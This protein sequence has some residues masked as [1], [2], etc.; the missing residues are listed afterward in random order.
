MECENCDK[1]LPVT[2]RYCPYCGEIIPIRKTK[3]YWLRAIQAAMLGSIIAT[4]LVG[5]L[6]G[7]GGWW[8]Q[9][10]TNYEVTNSRPSITPLN[11][12][13]TIPTNNT[14][15]I[16]YLKKLSQITTA[17]DIAI[18]GDYLF[19]T[20]PHG[21]QIFDIAIPAE[22]LWV[23]DYPSDVVPRAKIAI[24][25][26]YLYL[27][28]NT[29]MEIVNMANVVQ[30]KSL[31]TV[32]YNPN[33]AGDVWNV[34]LNRVYAY[35]AAGPHGLHIL[36]VANPYTPHR[37]T[38]YTIPDYEV[39]DVAIV[40]DQAYLALGSAGLWVL[41]IEPLSDIPVRQ[42]ALRTQGVVRRV[43]PLATT[44]YLVAAVG[45]GIEIINIT[46][47]N[48]PTSITYSDFDQQL[49]SVSDMVVVDNMVYLA[50]AGGVAL[51]DVSLPTSPTL[52]GFYQTTTQV[53]TLAVK[54]DYLYV[55]DWRGNVLLMRQQ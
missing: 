7:L 13:L 11:P 38:T 18:Q 52:L 9:S 35:I 30:P 15:T 46:N 5:G 28:D 2:I 55:V 26:G 21:L 43:L 45:H 24:L 39:W 27:V 3:P 53:A 31:S 37:L 16:I 20:D 50:T 8:Y 44:P 51:V 33:L 36:K 48:N 17:I 4:I 41:D 23:A 49:G 1:Q 14:S 10:T 42:G 25:P 22:P 19:L 34:S 12:N 47:P 40:D 32:A 29:Q 6:F 54:D